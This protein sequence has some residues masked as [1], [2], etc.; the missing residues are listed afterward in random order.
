MGHKRPFDDEVVDEVSPKHSRQSGAC[1]EFISRNDRTSKQADIMKR[2]D[3]GECSIRKDEVEYHDVHENGGYPDILREGAEETES[4]APRFV[5]LSHWSTSNTSVEDESS[6]EM[7]HMPFSPG[8]YNFDRPFRL[9]CSTDDVYHCLIDNPPRKQVPIGPEHQ[10]DI[11]PWGK[12]TSNG[13]LN[14]TRIMLILER[15]SVIQGIS[16]AGDDRIDCICPDPGS[17]RCVRVHI[18]EARDKLRRVLG[19]HAFTELGFND[20]GEVVA[21]KWENEEKQLF[22][23]VVYTNPVSLGKN[24]WDALSAVFPSRTKMEIVSYYFNVFMPRKRAEQNRCDPTNIHSDNDKWQG[25]DDDDD[26]DD[27]EDNDS[28]IESPVRLDGLVFHQNGSHARDYGEDDG[29]VS[30]DT[31]E[32]DEGTSQGHIH[33]F[34]TDSASQFSGKKV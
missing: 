17:V 8:Y 26:G 25:S 21:D 10:A 15:P 4:D 12:T 9:V 28:G 31:H 2:H 1:D 19:E 24:F 16:K 14:G 33:N 27:H 13:N 5:P 32:F 34:D 23:K 18:A 22:H 6:E 30:D 11:P 29:D 20:M 3:S 7:F